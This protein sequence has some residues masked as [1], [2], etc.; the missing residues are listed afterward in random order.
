[1]QQG[2]SWRRRE[3]K[4]RREMFSERE[5]RGRGRIGRE[6]HD[7]G[8]D[9]IGRWDDD[10]ISD[11]EDSQRRWQFWGTTSYQ[12]SEA[13]WKKVNETSL[14]WLKTVA[15]SWQAGGCELLLMIHDSIPVVECWTDIEVERNILLWARAVACIT[16]N[17]I[18]YVF[19]ADRQPNHGGQ[20]E[21]NLKSMSKMPTKWCNRVAVTHALGIFSLGLPF[22]P[23]TSPPLPDS[24]F[25]FHP[26]HV[27][28]RRCKWEQWYS[29]L[30]LQVVGYGFCMPSQQKTASGER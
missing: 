14:Y 26:M 24:H 16:V 2:Q 6:V 7:D 30:R 17:D 19:H 27:R 13:S 25:R 20:R 29:Y 10:E 1:M 9:G 28:W 11:E 5:D 23:Q 18:E 8:W 15:S 21:Q 22:P 4:N 12:K 3:G